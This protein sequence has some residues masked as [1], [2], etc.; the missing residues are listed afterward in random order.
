[1]LDDLI[2]RAREAGRSRVTVAEP[3][4]ENVRIDRQVL[5]RRLNGI[6]SRQLEPISTMGSSIRSAPIFAEQPAVN[7]FACCDRF[8]RRRRV[9]AR[10]TAAPSTILHS[11][12]VICIGNDAAAVSH[13]YSKASPAA[14]E[15]LHLGNA[16][17]VS[18][19]MKD[20]VSN[21]NLTYPRPPASCK[22]VRR[23]HQGPPSLV[24]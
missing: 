6:L 12:Q 1:M 4:S 14:Q 24:S 22:Q 17:R 20:L 3:R 11:P 23:N 10:A 18:V 2:V 8:D 15:C 19:G 13:G 21:L 9:A 16:N 7:E 5:C